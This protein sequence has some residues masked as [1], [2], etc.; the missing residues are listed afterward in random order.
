MHKYNNIT[1]HEWLEDHRKL[2]P[3]KGEMP[4]KRIRENT[5][6]KLFQY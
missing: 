3:N 5:I 2:Q 6:I 1:D 4:E